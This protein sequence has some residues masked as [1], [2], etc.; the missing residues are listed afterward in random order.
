MFKKIGLAVLF[1]ALGTVSALAADF[2]GTWS[3]EVQGRNGNTQTLTFDFHVDGTT[4]TGKVTT[5]RGSTDISNGK[6]DGDN[7]SFDQVMS[8]NGND[9]KITY[10]GK[11][12]GDTIKFSRQAGDRPA[13]EFVAKKGAP[14]PA[15]Q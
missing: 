5:P 9:M 1:L 8:F 13:M 14:A 4:L 3:A 10:T 6:V 15:A 12:D 2:S 11:A 7:I